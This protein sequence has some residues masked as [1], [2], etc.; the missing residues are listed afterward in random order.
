MTVTEVLFFLAQPAKAA[1]KYDRGLKNVE[2]LK[3]KFSR[4]TLIIQLQISFEFFKK[5]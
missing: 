5:S 3:L 2:C 1:F 4:S